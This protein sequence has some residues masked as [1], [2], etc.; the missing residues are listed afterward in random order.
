[1]KILFV[2][3]MNGISGSELYLLQLL[4]ELK[5][6][7]IEVEMLIAFKEESGRNIP[8]EL[9]VIDDYTFQINAEP[10]ASGIYN[11]RLQ[12]KTIKLLCY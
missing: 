7:G 11:I 5:K 12:S 3:H 9:I 6:K 2:Q 1:V 10:L 4:P 8:F